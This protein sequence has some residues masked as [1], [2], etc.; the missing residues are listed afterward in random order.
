[1]GSLFGWIRHR[2][3]KNMEGKERNTVTE[4]RENASEQRAERLDTE[5]GIRIV[6]GNRETY[7]MILDTYVTECGKR[8][9]RLMQITD[10]TGTE[11]GTIVHAFRG[12]SS[13]IGADYIADLS[14]RL[15]AA[16]R[17]ADTEY[18]DANTPVLCQKMTE[19][20]DIIRDYVGENS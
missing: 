4:D 16:S 14:E 5:R 2:D 10:R 9:E 7:C 20:F 12:S 8:L 18:V 11:Y 6:G 17:E 15:E 3:E 13:T 1:M 19:L